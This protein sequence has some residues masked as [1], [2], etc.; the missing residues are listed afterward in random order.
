MTM[1]W[2]TKLVM[3]A[4]LTALVSGSA[5]AMVV[6][7]N[8]PVA[9]T[10]KDWKYEIRDGKRVPKGNRVTNADGSWREEVRVGQCLTVKEKTAAGDYS[11]TRKCD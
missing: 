11:E 8:S 7:S 9:A 2:Q 3:G 6:Q 10:P 5:G 1:L 4:V